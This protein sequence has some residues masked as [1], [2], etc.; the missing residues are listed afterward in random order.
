MLRRIAWLLPL[1]YAIP[2]FADCTAASG[3]DRVG[4]LELYTSEGCSSCPP[5]D[6]WLSG[7]AAAGYGAD[8]VVPL[9]FHVDYWDYIGWKDRFANAGF[10]ARQRE[11]AASGGAGFVYT[12]QVVFNGEDLRGWQQRS[13]FSQAVSQSL[14]QPARAKIDLSIATPASGD[15]RV[16]TS[17]QALKPQDRQYAEVY[18]AVY[19]NNLSSAVN[20]GENSGRR[21]HHDYVVRQWMGPYRFDAKSDG[22]WQR[23]FSLD[24]GWKKRDAGVAAIVEDR[25]TGDVLQALALRICS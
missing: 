24:A 14:Q 22:T 20:A 10:S 4:L 19:E 9:A 5:A 17:A 8:K 15:I 6:E 23:S 13:R 2:V 25:R 3:P 7:I 11:I 12:P 18:I 16:N 21:L 1:M